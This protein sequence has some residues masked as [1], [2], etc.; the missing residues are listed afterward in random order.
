MYVGELTC[1]INGH[2][3]SELD[4]CEPYNEAGYPNPATGIWLLK[5]SITGKNWLSQRGGQFNTSVG[6]LMCLGL[7]FYN[8]TAQKTQWWGS[9]NLSEPKPHPLSNFSHLLKA[10]DEADTNI[11]WWSPGELYWICGRKSYTVP[12]PKWSGSWCWS[13][14]IHLSSCPHL[15]EG[16]ILESKCMKRIQ[17]A[18]QIGN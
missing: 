10:W 8:I 14:S 16:K 12:P 7:R 9:P 13:Q 15:P 3:R 17:C 5:A 2:G 4:P 18:L 1:E 6:S 11:K